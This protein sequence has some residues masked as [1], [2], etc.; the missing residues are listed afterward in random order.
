MNSVQDIALNGFLYKKRGG[1]G[2]HMPNSWQ[3]RYFTIKDGFISYYD[4]EDKSK[5]RGRI[6]LTT[7]FEIMRYIKISNAQ[8]IIIR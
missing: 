7:D 4:T 1:F 8:N 3:F 6:D 5:F 2:Q